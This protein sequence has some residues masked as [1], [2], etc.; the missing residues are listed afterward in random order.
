MQKILYI[1]TSGHR[2][3]FSQ[4]GIE[5]DGFNSVNLC[6]ASMVS[7]GQAIMGQQLIHPPKFTL[8]NKN[9]M[10]KASIYGC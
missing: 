8:K 4:V 6:F 2:I 3:S 10:T 1:E 9:H 7:R 5:I